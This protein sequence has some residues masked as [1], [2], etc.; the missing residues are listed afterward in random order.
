M[1]TALITAAGYII[2][3]YYDVK[4]DVI[5]RPQSVVIER[6]ISRKQA[7]IAHLF[8]STAALIIGITISFKIFILFALSTILLWWYS[9][10]LKKQP[11]WGNFTIA[12][13]SATSVLVMVI[14]YNKNTAP[15][16]YYSVLIFISTII[17]EI[18]K[19]MEDLN[20]DKA[21]G[22]RTLPIVLGI[23]KT[24]V[25]VTLLTLSFLLTV[26]LAP[27]Y[28]S[29]PVIYLLFSCL[30]VPLII[31]FLLFLQKADTVK[32]FHQLSSLCKW[33]MAIGV[34]SILFMR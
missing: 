4:I 6:I 2:N 12:S 11:F 28:L 31:K 13:L 22:C 26:C 24:K 10:Y 5:N 33:M 1:G 32:Q 9:N 21:Y 14:V 23:R 27:L 29:S 15:L 7:I 30:L 17:R 18:V 25:I 20:G 3:D 34:L 19:D 16:Y 8:I